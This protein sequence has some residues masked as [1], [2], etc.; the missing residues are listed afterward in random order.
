VLHE[1]ITGAPGEVTVVALGP[2]TNLALLLRTRHDVA[3]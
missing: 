1:A 3:E 2:L